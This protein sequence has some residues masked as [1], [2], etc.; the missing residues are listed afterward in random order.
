MRDTT[1][2]RRVLMRRTCRLSSLFPDGRLISF[3]AFC[4]NP[5]QRSSVVLRGM[6]SAL[7]RMGVVLLHADLKLEAAAAS[8]CSQLGIPMVRVGASGAAQRQAGGYDPLYG[9]DRSGVLRALGVADDHS[10]AGYVGYYLT[11]LDTL[12]RMSPG[13]FGRYAYSL[14]A[15]LRLSSLPVVN[16]QTNVLQA[17]SSALSQD[18]VQSITMPGVQM[19]VYSRVSALAQRL[20]G[21]LCPVLAQPGM[22][23]PT[24]TTSLVALSTM[25]AVTSVYLPSG[26]VGT[27][28]YLDVELDYL[29]RSRVPFMLVLSGIDVAGT[30]MRQRL[31][32]EQGAGQSYAVGVASSNPLSLMHDQQDVAALFAKLN[33]IVVF[34]CTTSQVAESVSSIFGT[35][36]HVVRDRNV[37]VS[38]GH[39]WLFGTYSEGYAEHTVKEQNVRPEDLMGTDR[40]ALVVWEG[41]PAL[42]DHLDEWN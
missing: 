42:V 24:P 28:D 34:P 1:Y 14:G 13:R 35:Y 15:L 36:D 39:G 41:D 31:I 23:L 18:L 30:D 32:S 4:G 3:G 16:L 38:R 27:L 5:S 19:D 17:F 7:G 29:V 21:T 37:G 2:A 20:S 33:R 6:R 25:C 26:D 11:I 10:A 8:L 22:S 9:L 12:Y 40:G